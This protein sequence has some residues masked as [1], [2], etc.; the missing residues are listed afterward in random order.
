L[1]ISSAESPVAA[2]VIGGR[3]V[4][5]NPAGD[6]GDS[7]ITDEAAVFPD[8]RLF[9]SAIWKSPLLVLRGGILPDKLT[10][11]AA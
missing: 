3:N 7:Y 6:D 8:R 4:Y 9:N 5:R 10:G 1:H 11:L 2:A